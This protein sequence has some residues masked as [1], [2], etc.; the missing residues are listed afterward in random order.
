MPSTAPEIYGIISALGQRVSSVESSL[1]NEIRSELLKLHLQIQKDEARFKSTTESINSLK[2]QQLR[3]NALQHEK[4]VEPARSDV[5][6]AD[7]P[8]L[9]ERAPVNQQGQEE[10]VQS[11][12]TNHLARHFKDI[13]SRLVS[14]VDNEVLEELVKHLATRDELKKMAKKKLTASVDSE[15]IRELVEAKMFELQDNIYPETENRAPGNQQLSLKKDLKT[16]IS[17]HLDKLE[18]SLLSRLEEK[19]SSKPQDLGM[20]AKSDIKGWMKTYAQKLFDEKTMVLADN[21]EQIRIQMS[22]VLQ[23]HIDSCQAKGSENDETSVADGEM[24]LIVR[25]LKREFDEKLFLVCS[26]LSAC[27]SQFSNHFAQPFYRVGQ[28]VWK[29]GQ[30]KMGSG[31]PWNIQTLN[32]GT[33][34]S[35]LDDFRFRQF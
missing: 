34:R 22:S 16:Y 11:I 10:F 32:T 17:K 12:V 4:R 35:Q 9:Q 21:Y 6:S 3:F 29:S 30:L 23:K 7:A 8:P 18:V 13:E 28:W 2:E 33:L 5:F 31:V 1:E 20:G 26:D 14:K 25:R 19:V 24:D 27:K 15:K